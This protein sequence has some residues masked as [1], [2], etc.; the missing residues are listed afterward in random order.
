M[1]S[2]QNVKKVSNRRKK[3]ENEKLGIHTAPTEVVEIE[4]N[5]IENWLI[6]LKHWLQINP[7]TARRIILGVVLVMVLFLLLLFTHSALVEK[8]NSQYYSILLSYEKL[9]EDAGVAKVN[10]EKLKKL[11]ELSDKLC[12]S[13]WSTRYS[14]N[15]CLLSAVFANEAGNKKDSAE[16]LSKFSTNTPNKALGAYTTFLAAYMFE[17]GKDL[18][19]SM[20]LYKKL[21]TLVDEKT[22]R[23]FSLFHLGRLYYY[24]DKFVEAEKSFK[25]IL[26]KYKASAY[27]GDAKN[28]LLLIQL[29]KAKPAGAK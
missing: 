27:Q 25:E 15:G 18:D 26:E 13:T 3:I 24:N 22:G 8:Q 12:K 11:Q 20:D 28:Y 1:A 7:S 10:G 21:D 23:D 5:I 9:R 29:K 14:N 6:S 4:R 17:T 2:N 16:F 19:K